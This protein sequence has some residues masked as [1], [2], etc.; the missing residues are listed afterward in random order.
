MIASEHPFFDGNKKT[1]IMTA[2]N[3]LGKEGY[4]LDAKPVDV[5]NLMHKISRY[6]VLEEAGSKI[7]DNASEKGL[8]PRADEV[9]KYKK[10]GY[11]LWAK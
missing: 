3:I 10:T 1:A 7:R 2:E 4:F 9:R 8:S 6:G 11:K 5:T